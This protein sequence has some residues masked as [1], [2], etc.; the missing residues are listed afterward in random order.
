LPRA[1]VTLMLTAFALAT[2]LAAEESSGPAEQFAARV[3]PE[4]RGVYQYRRGD[5]MLADFLPAKEDLSDWRTM[6][7][8]EFHGVDVWVDPIEFVDNFAANQSELCEGFQSLSMSSGMENGYPTSVNMLICPKMAA[9]GKGRV[10][11]LKAVHGARGYYVAALMRRAD[12]FAPETTPVVPE[13]VAAW[14]QF[15]RQVIV[16]VPGS[17][18]HPCPDSSGT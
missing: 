2:A 5:I 6:L 4:W 3:P 14:S 8:Y 17:S 18:E 12:E 15:M 9:S 11:L 10:T 7:T 13:E 1:I 16:C